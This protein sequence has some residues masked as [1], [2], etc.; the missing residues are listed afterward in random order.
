MVI[1]LT[2][3]IGAGKSTVASFF[4]EWGAT[5]ID[6][7][8]LGSHILEQKRNEVID[9]FGEDILSSSRPFAK[10][11]EIDR[12]KLGKIVFSNL[13]NKRL[14]DSI[15]HPPL[16]LELKK[17][18]ESF[19]VKSFSSIPQSCGV[20]RLTLV[21]DCALIYEWSIEGWFHKVILVKADY[22]KKLDRLLSMGYTQEEAKSRIEAQL[23][24]NKKRADFVIENNGNLEILMKS[25]KVVWDKIIAGIN[26]VVEQ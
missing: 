18:I 2:G 17:Q 10:R 25:A 15:I 7:D 4:K 14:F 20:K 23:S 1:G 19:R 21:V 8:K 3:G 12:K 24:D 16:I 22:N 26:E 5:I 13:E 9:A 11:R 6:V